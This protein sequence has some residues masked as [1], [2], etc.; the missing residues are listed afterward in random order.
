MPSWSTRQALG[1]TSRCCIDG[2]AAQCPGDCIYQDG[3]H[4]KTPG[5][6]YYTALITTVLADATLFA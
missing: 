2:L 5:A 1:P 6:E 4:L 3:F